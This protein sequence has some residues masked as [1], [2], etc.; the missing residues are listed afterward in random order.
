M[1]HVKV[2]GDGLIVNASA[3]MP[4][5]FLAAS[6]D[7]YAEQPVHGIKIGGQ[8]RLKNGGEMKLY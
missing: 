5:C 3:D 2:A 6:S 4:A 8:L 1:D 7:P